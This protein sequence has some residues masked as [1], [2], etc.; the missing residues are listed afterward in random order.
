MIRRTH[1]VAAVLA[2]G[3]ALPLLARGSL[4]A[5]APAPVVSSVQPTGYKVRVTLGEPSV[6][7]GEFL[8]TPLAE[9]DVPGAV[10]ER[11]APGAPPLP[12]RTVFLR[13]P[14]GARVRASVVPSPARSLGTLRPAPFP[15]LLTDASMRERVTAADL[16]AALQA[17]GSWRA[18]SVQGLA[19]TRVMAARGERLLAVTI[20]P[21]SWDASSGSA[22]FVDE[23]AIEVT[24]DGPVEPLA[25]P[26]S[27]RA[28]TAPSGAVGPYYPSRAPRTAPASAGPAR[29][30][31]SLA[32]RAAAIG[33][34]RVTPDPLRTWVRLNV[35]RPGLYR[36]TASD[37]A[38]AGVGVGAIDP[39]TIRIF[40]ST[41]G[42]LPENVNVDQGPD[43][44]RECAIEVTG[45]G[46]GSLDP[47]DRI[48]VYA[49]GS[50]GFGYDLVFGGG[51]AYQ[52]TQHSDVE[53]LWMTWGPGPVATPPRRMAT[54][55]AALDAVAAPTYL[56]VPHRVHYEE[57]RLY[58]ADLFEPGVR[59]ERWFNRILFQG[60]RVRFDLTMP[61]AQPGGS[62]DVL[63]RVW[64]VGSS[65]GA[66][67]PDH[68]ARIYWNR[69][70]VDTAGWDLSLHQDLAATGVITQ[71]RDTLDVEVPALIDPGPFPQRSDR[72]YLAWFEIGYPRQLL[73][74]N[75]TLQFAA[76]DSLPNAPVRY[77]I[78]GISD[79]SAVW[80]LDRTDPE[81]PVRLVGG[82]VSGG[83]APFAWTVEDSAGDGYRPRY[84]LVSTTR[85]AT[86]GISV[87]AP[88]S[89]ANTISDL[90]DPSNEADYVIVA[91]PAFL[92]QAE[93]L[94]AYR[95]LGIEGIPA[96]RVRIATTERVFAQLGAGLPSPVAIR[97]LMQYAAAHWTGVPPSYLCL[98]GDAT[99]DPKNYIGF[100]TPDLV[101][102]Y[103]NYYDVSQTQ[104]YN[105][106]DFY[107]I[108]DGPGDLLLDLAVGRLPAGTTAEAQTL[109][110]GKLRLYEESQDFD[111]WRAR[112]ILCADDA[113]QRDE[114]DPV[115]NEHVR[116]SERLD[117]LHLPYPVERAKVYLNDFAF[118]DTTHQSKPAAREEFIAQINRGAWL[119]NYVGHG[120]DQVLADEQVFRSADATRLT[121]ATRPSIFGYF[122]CTVGK[123]DEPSGEGLGE[124]LLTLPGG[125][126]VA[127]LAASGLT[128]PSSSGPL[129]ESFLDELFPFAPRVDT[130]RTAGL[131]FARAKNELA[132]PSNDTVRKYGFLGDP[133]L[134]PP[135]PR[136]AGVWEKQPLDS[137]LRGDVVTLR[138]HAVM[139][140]ADSTRDQVSM[141]NAD[142]LLQGPPFI[143]SQ[144]AQVSG[145]P[146]T[147]QIPGPTI[148]RGTVPLDHGS[149]EV[150]FVVPTDGRL[151]G[152]G[153]KLRA[154]LS[155]A[156]GRGVG[157]AVDSLR[158]AAASSPRVDATPPTIQVV[159]PSGP[160]SL[161][162]P[163][164]HVTL[165]LSDSSG[166]DLT[167]LDNAHSIFVIVDDRGT[168]YELTS[169]FAYDQGSYT[170]GQVDF[171][172]PAGLQDGAHRLEIH[173]SDT[174]RNIGVANVIV[175]VATEA[176]SG[177]AL[178][179]D[180][181]F[182]YPNPFPRETYLH[183][184][185]NQPAKL[186]IKVLT[187]AGRR[188]REIE[189]DGAAGEN[190]IPWDG[191]D[192]EGENVAI[193][194]YLFSVTA[195]SSSGGRAKAVGRA[196]RTQ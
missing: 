25:G 172:I 97:N 45:A 58:N 1:A 123:F 93:A 17:Q 26:A 59:W 20:R 42:D 185:L 5:S 91:P 162:H 153:G 157:L 80:L 181:V 8:G 89:S 129:N 66:G 167:R 87:Y 75:D 196:L 195:E 21:V 170:T 113:V 100:G 56:A 76:P 30:A 118:S 165:V 7:R 9:I 116:Q 13:I 125:G 81:S 134:R 193:G 164:S 46:D 40:R 10:P 184:R 149:F 54:R 99:F 4:A 133:A 83:A 11:A 121:N 189:W 142:L 22:S 96:P 179:L 90:L 55:S 103:S 145:T 155:Q 131:A 102:T 16:E 92:A 182:N 28:S 160:D 139:G 85:A 154:L 188:V 49:T 63:V 52:E 132:G 71:G 117:G 161:L 53:T 43:S 19:T 101:P 14:W 104:Q 106:D 12:A 32:G 34:L 177:T 143:R 95:S 98:L 183:A 114:I 69:A 50:T 141:G 6:V 146:Q 148:F 44:L 107:G 192:S 120:S 77:Q 176:V 27:A 15:Y 78:T 33:P 48:Y 180:Q 108:L 18:P 105:S 151:V 175:D 38:A 73:A 140:P 136:G 163:G 88:T 130:L 122:S 173:A 65:I 72:S 115:G 135:L 156:G 35:L 187:V 67:L 60:S 124:L 152:R 47:A 86:P 84:S 168:P 70:L 36:V 109:T 147:Y 2:L 82:F 29:G 79:T 186:R 24:W 68:V 57:N 41:P 119:T 31:R 178:R 64:G 94:V 74:V 166:I 159:Y 39:A 171:T 23:V 190:Y 138:G 174:F 191:R 37:L 137:V 150:T 62:A 3:T 111:M 144:F 127:S 112:G 128:L 194:V 126:A 169:G 61:G 51:P 158:I 110:A